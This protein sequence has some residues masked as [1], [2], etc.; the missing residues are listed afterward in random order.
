MDFVG[1]KRAPGPGRPDHRGGFRE[2]NGCGGPV[3][4]GQAKLIGVADVLVLSSGDPDPDLDGP[5]LKL[6]G[7]GL[8]LCWPNVARDR[9][10]AGDESDTD[11]AR[12]IAPSDLGGM[13]SNRRRSRSRRCSSFTRWAKT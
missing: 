9:L 2:A 5:C 7:P 8:A 11:R 12:Q 1:E 4:G 13:G 10:R 3:C 6:D